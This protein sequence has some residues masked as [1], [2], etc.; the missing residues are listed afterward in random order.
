MVLPRLPMFRASPR[1]EHSTIAGVRG[2]TPS[3]NGDAGR[4]YCRNAHHISPRRQ[5]RARKSFSVLARPWYAISRRKHEARATSTSRDRQHALGSV[6]TRSAFR[7]PSPVL[8]DTFHGSAAQSHHSIGWC[9]LDRDLLPHRHR[10]RQAHAPGVGA[11]LPLPEDRRSRPGQD[12]RPAGRAH[13]QG[14]RL[15][16][17]PEGEAVLRALAELEHAICPEPDPT[18]TRSRARRRQ[19]TTRSGPQPPAPG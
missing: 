11:P 8:W 19:T 18:D 2:A 7:C 5:A 13:A 17:T 15:G 12:R 4:Y 9:S 3:Q 16:L 10:D 1:I 14:R 6:V